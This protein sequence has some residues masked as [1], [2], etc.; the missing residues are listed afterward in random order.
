LNLEETKEKYP[1]LGIVIDQIP[2]IAIA[3]MAALAPIIMGILSKREGHPSKSEVNASTF[4]KLIYFQIVQVFLVPLFAG[5]SLQSLID[6]WT[7]LKDDPSLIVDLLGKSIPN[8][9]TLYMVYLILK[10]ATD[11]LLELWRLIP[12]VC[13]HI[14][15]MFAPKLTARQRRSPWLGLKPA[16]QAGDFDTGSKLPDFYLAILLVL[17]FCSIAPLFSYFGLFYF[18]VAELVWRRQFLY[19]YDPSLQSKGVYWPRMHMFLC[20]ALVFAQLS[21]LGLVT[22][23]LAKYVI[24]FSTIL[25][26]LT[27]FYYVYATKLFSRSGAYLPL[28]VCARLDTARAS[29]HGAE[30][31]EDFVFVQPVLA[32]QTVE[33]LKPDLME[34]QTRVEENVAHAAAAADDDDDDGARSIRQNGSK[35][36][37]D[38]VYV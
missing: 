34:L 3:I 27:G 12:L 8:Q 37:V 25:P 11:I 29:T 30:A 6:N 32:R 19:V 20:L 38:G 23:K 16:T 9:S 2:P 21:F 15:K 33:P 10:V 31:L 14:Y 5:S 36:K 7:Q 13:G 35:G 1:S 22:L 18:S 4:G 28:F 26:F 24:L 17:T